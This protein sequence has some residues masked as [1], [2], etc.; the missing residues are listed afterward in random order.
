MMKQTKKQTKK[1]IIATSSKSLELD[2][3]DSSRDLTTHR[4]RHPECVQSDAFIALKEIKK[5]IVNTKKAVEGLR[6]T[7]E[8]IFTAKKLR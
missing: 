8:K 2:L 6:E 4:E 5:E 1:R 7:I 3:A